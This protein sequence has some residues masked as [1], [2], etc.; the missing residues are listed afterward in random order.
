MKKLHGFEEQGAEK[1]CRDAATVSCTIYLSPD[2][3]A[4]CVQ[5]ARRGKTLPGCGNSVLYY[6]F[7]YY[8]MKKRHGFEEQGAKPCR[9]AATVSC[10]I[11]LLPDKKVARV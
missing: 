9:D 2:E 5:R 6:I 11:F 1:P 3:K 8:Q 4:A 7:L 10:T